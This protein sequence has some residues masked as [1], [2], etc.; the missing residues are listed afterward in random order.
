MNS[1]LVVVPSPVISSCDVAQRAIM[2][3]VGCWIC[4][5][6]SSDVPSLVS[7]IWPAPPTSIFSVP[8][9]PRLVLSTACIPFAALMFTANAASAPMTWAFWLSCSTPL[10]IALRCL[11]Q[12]VYK[13]RLLR[14]ADARTL[15]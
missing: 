11:V 4:I 1:T 6:R 3:A 15:R 12:E 10:A 7:L 13:E 9:G 5:S 14:S 2:M 8:L